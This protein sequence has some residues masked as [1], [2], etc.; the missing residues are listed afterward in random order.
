M[1]GLYGVYQEGIAKDEVMGK[2]VTAHIFEASR[3]MLKSTVLMF[4]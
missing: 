2:P 3:A 1:L 4:L